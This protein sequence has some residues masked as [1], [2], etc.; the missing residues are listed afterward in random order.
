MFA[1][2]I[3]TCSL[4]PSIPDTNSTVMGHPLV[5][6]GPLYTHPV[7][8][9]SVHCTRARIIVMAQHFQDTRN[10]CTV[11]MH[12]LYLHFLVLRPDDQQYAESISQM[13][14][15]KPANCPNY[16]PFVMERSEVCCRN[17]CFKPSLSLSLSRY[18][19]FVLCNDSYSDNYLITS[20]LKLN[21]MRSVLM[22]T[23]HHTSFAINVE[24][25]IKK[26]CM[27]IL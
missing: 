24:N 21:L 5:P 22:F 7:V 26:V 15:M 13:W 14:N 25:G 17:M 4:V 12:Y 11:R 18:S 3:E 8:S 16:S 20:L 10:I 2:L 9:S 6:L 23:S 19:F 1:V 27:F